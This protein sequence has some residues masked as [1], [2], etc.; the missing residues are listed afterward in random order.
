VDSN[1][2]EQLNSTWVKKREELKITRHELQQRVLALR[3]ELES[4][5]DQL[6]GVPF[7]VPCGEMGTP[8]SLDRNKQKFILQ[9]VED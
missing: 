2:N 3:T 5:R 1:Q 6:E 7:D 4:Y 8:R 9:L